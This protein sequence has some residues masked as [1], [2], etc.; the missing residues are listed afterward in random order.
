MDDGLPCSFLAIHVANLELFKSALMRVDAA[1][2]ALRP[3]LVRQH[4]V[5]L[6]HHLYQGFQGRRTFCKPLST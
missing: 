2:S 6:S 3:D 5:V 1:L 4:I